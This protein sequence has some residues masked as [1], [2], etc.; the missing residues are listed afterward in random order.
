MKIESE[1]MKKEGKNDVELEVL[2]FYI[3]INYIYTLEKIKFDK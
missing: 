2:K 1:K 3:D